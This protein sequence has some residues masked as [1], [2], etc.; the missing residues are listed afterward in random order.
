MH[1]DGSQIARTTTPP[2][3]RPRCVAAGVL[4]CSAGLI[5]MGGCETDGYIDPS[6]IGRWE[7]TPTIM[8]ILDRMSAIEDEPTEYVQSS[9]INSGDLL[10]EIDTYRLGPGDVIEVRIRDFFQL[11]AEEPFQRTVDQR[12]YIDIPRLPSIRVQGKTSD[13]VI[14]NVEAAVRERNI[15]D[16]PVV[17]VSLL[18]QRKQTFSVIGA[19]QNPGTYFIPSPDYRLLEGVTAAGGINETIQY[20]YVIRQIPLTDE[21]AGRLPGADRGTSPAPGTKPSGGPPPKKGEDLIDLIDELSKPKPGSPVMLGGETPAAP[22]RVAQPE[23]PA[24]DLPDA[25]T[26]QPVP[27]SNEAQ[28]RWV[29]VDGK[30]VK[31]QPAPEA[32]ERG[33][34]RNL[35]TQRVIKVPV[36]PLLAG[37]ADVNIIVRPGDVVRVPV[38]RSGLVYMTGQVTRPGPYTLPADGRLTLLRA[39]DAAGGLNG[40]AI[41]ERVD[42]TRMVSNDRQATIRLNVRAISEQTQPDIYLKPDDRINIGTNFWATPLAVIRGG[43]RFTYGFGFVLD[44]NFDNEIYGYQNPANTN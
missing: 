33:E 29:F 35:V 14:A 6:I 15:N 41:P 16:R 24:I 23:P 39:I 25:R 42:L 19:A 21:A 5:I 34:Q 11:G 22:M 13:E 28:G 37:A 32:A 43:F 38:P 31:T 1:F 12:G 8:P 20:V 26:A 18:Q 44:R 10:P 9:Q 2:R 36:G 17:V 3:R 27:V 40:I 4:L 30:W 7:N